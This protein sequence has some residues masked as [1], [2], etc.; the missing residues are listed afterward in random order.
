M[1]LLWHI[2]IQCFDAVCLFAWLSWLLLNRMI[3]RRRSWQSALLNHVICRHSLW[4]LWVTRATTCSFALTVISRGCTTPSHSTTLG[5]CCSSSFIST[6][7][8]TLP[9]R[10][11][12]HAR[13]LPQNQR[14]RLPLRRFPRL[15]PGTSPP[16]KR[17]LHTSMVTL[18]MAPVDI[19]CVPVRTAALMEMLPQ[20]W[21]DHCDWDRC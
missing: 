3:C 17:S 21:M 8:P 11:A 18:R 12:E 13:K 4:L 9:Q 15:P 10:A 1:W 7:P 16:Q 6:T 19:R 5:R 2:F 20:C 14:H